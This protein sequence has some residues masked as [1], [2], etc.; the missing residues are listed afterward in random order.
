MSVFRRVITVSGSTGGA[1]V[2]TATADSDIVINGII[3]AVY[4]EY[5]GSPPAATT[6]LTIV[7]ANNDP[8]MTILT[9][10]NGATDGWYAPVHAA[11]DV[12]DGVATGNG[13][14]VSVNDYITATIA[15][16]ND[17]DGVIVTIVYV[18]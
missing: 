18:Q 6:D 15:Q 14:V 7:E 13:M 3:T 9:I 12:D 5:T 4:L 10:T 1:G 16:A 11:V 8:A 2:S 17:D